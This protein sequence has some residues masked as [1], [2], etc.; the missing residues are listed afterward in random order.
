MPIETDFSNLRKHINAVFP[1]LDEVIASRLNSLLT[2][3]RRKEDLLCE[4]QELEIEV[5]AFLNDAG[6][7]V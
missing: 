1:N 3:Q 4:I 2:L 5:D 7:L 6:N